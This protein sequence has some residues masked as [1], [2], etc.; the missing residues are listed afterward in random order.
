MPMSMIQNFKTQ[1]NVAA[2]G[3][4]LANFRNLLSKILK[5]YEPI[6]TWTEAFSKTQMQRIGYIISLYKPTL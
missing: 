4:K 1:N 3:N 6:R 2:F 5:N